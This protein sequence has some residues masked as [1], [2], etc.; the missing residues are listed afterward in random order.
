MS[1]F[2]SLAE[3]FEAHRVRLRAVAYR[4]LGSLA[5]ADDAVQ[6][7]WLRLSRADAE[8]RRQPRGL[9]D[10]DRRPDVPEHAALAQDAARGAARRCTCPTRSSAASAAS[11][12]RT[13][14]CSPTRS[15][16]R[17]SGGARH[18]GSRRAA[19]VRPARHVRPAL[20]R[21]RPHRGAFPGSDAGSSPAGPGAGCGAE[22]PGS[23]PDIGAPA[24]GRRRLLRR[25]ARWRPRRS[26]SRCSIP[27][28]CCGPTRARRV[29][30]LPSVVNG[31]AAVA[32]AGAHV[33]RPAARVRSGPGERRRGAS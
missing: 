6:E 20:R 3:E 23:R 33:R 30:A 9:A 13:R 16:S 2:D 8:R 1:E 5:E 28:W 27:M 29:R 11:T 18:A 17:C 15:G 26:A 25:G 22:A 19:G 32:G 7:T 10:H 4:M 12:P 14:R 31:A 24:R 21:D